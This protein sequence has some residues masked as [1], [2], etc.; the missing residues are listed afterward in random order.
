MRPVL[1]LCIR[2][3]FIWTCSIPERRRFRH[4]ASDLAGGALRTRQPSTK[5]ASHASSQPTSQQPSQPHVN[6]WGLASS[7]PV[8]RCVTG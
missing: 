5:P 4:K 8:R 1:L 2:L 6:P 3:Q 7:A